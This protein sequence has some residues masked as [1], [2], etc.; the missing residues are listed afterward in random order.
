MA[1]KQDFADSIF[2]SF[3]SRTLDLAASMPDLVA[4]LRSELNSWQAATKAPVPT[5]PNPK[6]VLHDVEPGLK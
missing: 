4:R 3:L 5:E 1:G 6:C 2:D